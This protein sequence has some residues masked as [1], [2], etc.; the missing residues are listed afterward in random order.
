MK[1]RVLSDL[2]LEFDA[3]DNQFHPGFGDVL[4]LSGDICVVR[5]YHRYHKFFEQCVEG[6]NKVFYTLGN[7]EYYNGKWETT[8][9]QLRRQLPAGITLMNNQSEF[10][11]GWH[12]VGAPL[13]ANFKGANAAEMSICEQGMS[14]YHVITKR[15]RAIKPMD[16]LTEH[17]DTRDWLE[18]CIP[19]LR[20]NVFVF[21]HHAPSMQSVANNYRSAEVT[22]AYATDM[23]YFITQ[24]P[25]IKY[26]SHGHI[27]ESHSYMV[28]EC[29]V[30][31]NPRGYCGHGENPGFNP[32]ME[33]ELDS[34]D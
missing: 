4:V 29:N 32:D 20:G 24:N 26:W 5:D 22:G 2:H 6:Y 7:H 28:G 9:Q 30:V 21:T 25:N 12:F 23:E 8:E 3:S 15:G 34:T 10:Y 31:S 33:L 14:D 19:N 18:K 16:T 11:K 13:W 1:V 17:M 27:H